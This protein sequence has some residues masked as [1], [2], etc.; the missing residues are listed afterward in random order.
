MQLTSHIYRV[1]VK[2]TKEGYRSMATRIDVVGETEKQLRV[3]SCPESGL[4]T[5]IR[6]V[7][8]NIV[9]AFGYPL[10]VISFGGFC[11]SKDLDEFT[12]KC[13]SS[14][15]SLARYNFV[16]ALQV[17]VTT[18]KNDPNATQTVKGALLQ[19]LANYGE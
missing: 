2:A 8:L 17:F 15:R 13:E 12:K 7:E 9:N 5:I 11:L 3:Q 6:K 16:E 4:R 19:E 18:M 10:Q 1:E 14:T